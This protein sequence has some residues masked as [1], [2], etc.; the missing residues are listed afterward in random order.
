MTDITDHNKYLVYKTD[1]NEE[2]LQKYIRHERLYQMTKQE[3]GIS[4][5]KTLWDY[6]VFFASERLQRIEQLSTLVEDKDL[7]EGPKKAAYDK[8]FLD[9]YFK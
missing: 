4:K 6:L 3:G 5:N 9:E 2:A 1:S 8:H 7:L